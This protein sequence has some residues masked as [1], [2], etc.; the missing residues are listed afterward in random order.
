MAGIK[1][2]ITDL[3]ALIET[4]SIKY[5][6]VWNNQFQWMEEQSIEAFPM[7]CA[8]V[9]LSSPK[10]GAGLGIITS[11]IV[12][13]IHIGANELDAQDGTMEQNVNIF[14]LRDELIALLNYKELTGCSGLQMVNEEQDYSHT[15]V[16]HYI[17]EFLCSFIDTSGD[18]TRGQIEHFPTDLIID[19]RTIVTTI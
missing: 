19:P 6:R 12:F 4:S 1:T 18:Q 8:F 11:D 10:G 5:A 15:N 16:Y 2:P 3:L 13:R 9:E 14:A 17:I 7:P